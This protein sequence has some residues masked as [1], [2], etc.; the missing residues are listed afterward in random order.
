MDKTTA[1][2]GKGSNRTNA[3]TPA[4]LPIGK[5][6]RLGHAGPVSNPADRPLT[7]LTV[8]TPDGPFSI[9]G[10]DQTIVAAG[11]TDDLATLHRRLPT[12]LRARAL[13]PVGAHDASLSAAVAAV[14]AFYDNDF[15]PILA[16]DVQL[17]GTEFQRTG[18][19]VLRQVPAGTLL[20][21]TE[22]AD[23]IGRPRA[24]RAA[25]AVCARNVVALFVPCHRVVRSDGTLG[26]FGWGEAVKRSLVER[27]SAS[28]SIR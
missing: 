5:A 7:A 25:A 13:L 15:A 21:Y 11:W 18:W 27:E 23:E 6:A 3:E 12:T 20:S 1:R 2:P 19:Q 28:P 16:V 8:T 9:V 24:V 26:G 22:F 17:F 4:P 10:A 14:E